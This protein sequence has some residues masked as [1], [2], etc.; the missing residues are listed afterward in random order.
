MLPLALQLCSSTLNISGV[1]EGGCY[2]AFRGWNRK[3]GIVQDQDG[4][5][6]VGQDSGGS[7]AFRDWSTGGCLRGQYSD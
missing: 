4:A 3:A 7:L 2:F 6:I 5:A 1:G